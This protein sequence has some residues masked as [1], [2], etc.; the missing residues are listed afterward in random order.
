MAKQPSEAVAVAGSACWLGNVCRL[1]EVPQLR[2]LHEA[3][4]SSQPP[5]R[6]QL[7]THLSS[8]PLP[9][10]LMAVAVFAVATLHRPDC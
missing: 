9:T 7:H 4:P 1:P 2:H 8:E 5:T 3:L 6:A 10:F